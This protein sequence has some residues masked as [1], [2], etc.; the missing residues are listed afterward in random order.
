MPPV[1]SLQVA[2]PAGSVRIELARVPPGEFVIGSATGNEAPARRVRIS[3]AF[4]IG[5]FPITR[6][7]Y[8]AVMGS[9]AGEGSLPVADVTHLQ[10]VEFC[11][12][13]GEAAGADVGL[14]TEA[15][16]EYACRAGTQTRYW[17]GDDEDSLARVGWYSANAGGRAHPVG[18]K[19]ANAFGLHDV[20]GN[21][22]EH[23]ADFIDD[24]ATMDAV[25]PIGRL[26]GAYGAMR[27]GGWMHDADDCRSARRLA[28][29]DMFGGAGLRVMLG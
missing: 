12:R 13:L 8:A 25:D 20:H 9:S 19:P 15:R 22:W 11:A 2:F 1:R 17:S 6:A 18:L 21:V 27:G 7:Q 28:S 10:A 23:C 5:R 24:Y 16:W 14:P 29:D 26:T 3:R 4:E